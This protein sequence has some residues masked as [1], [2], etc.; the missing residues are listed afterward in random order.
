MDD[1]LKKEAINIPGW[2][3]IMR[4]MRGNVASGA[5]EGI[6]EGIE[7]A[8]KDPGFRENLKQQLRQIGVD[9]AKAIGPGAAAGGIAAG[10]SAKLSDR[11]VGNAVARGMLVGGLTGGLSTRMV[12]SIGPA[13]SALIGGLAALPTGLLSKKKKPQEKPMKNKYA[14]VTLDWYDDKGATL[15][16][17]FPTPDTLPGVIKEADIRPKEKLAHEDFALVAIDEGTVMRKFACHDPGT[18]AMSV[19]YFM[20]HGDKLPEGAMKLAAANLC[21]ACKF[22]GL[23]APGVLEELAGVEKTAAVDITGQAPVPQIKVA[24]PL[25]ND[26]YAVVMP[27]GSRYYPIN[28]WDL[29][30]KAEVY[31]S[32]EGIR[33]HPEIRRQF[34]TK[35]AAKAEVV[36]FPLDESIKEAGAQ[37]FAAPG[38]LK[39]AVEM[40]KTACAPGQGR[41]FLDEL[42][43][44]SASMGPAVYAECLR[45]FDVQNGLDRGWDRVVLDP[46]ASTFGIDKTAKVVWEQGAD[47]VREEDLINLARNHSDQ[48]DGLYNEYF[49]MEFQKDPVGVFMSLPDPQKKLLGRLAADGSSMGEQEFMATGTDDGAGLDHN[50][51]K[52]KTTFGS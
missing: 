32:E 39:A 28:T 44:K 24:A 51:K 21:E 52:F 4:A 5:R 40:R 9:A 30:K 10:A 37:T 8:V 16:S 14:G 35:L 43:E 20:E 6:R 11:E 47:R 7:G 48:V 3:R 31:F 26:D 29:I 41:E 34:A 22:H 38:H 23:R 18:T 25:S 19:I 17:K 45:R 13:E 33:M 50:G 1:R 27:D 49:S 42:L 46:W 15:K 36:G 12:K 2:D